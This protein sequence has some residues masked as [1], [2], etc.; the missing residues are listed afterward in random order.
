MEMETNLPGVVVGPRLTL[1]NV[2][3]RLAEVEQVV[4][5][6]AKTLFTDDSMTQAVLPDGAYVTNT[7]N[8]VDRTLE[9]KDNRILGL[10]QANEALRAQIKVKDREIE[11]LTDL[12]RL[13]DKRVDE[14]HDAV[15]D[16]RV[17]LDS[18]SDDW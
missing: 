17:A 12:V 15:I 1:D 7:T 3:A 8:V 6:I 18:L 4:S 5:T 11:R 10:E 14:Y 13:Q 16:I 9:I 2:N